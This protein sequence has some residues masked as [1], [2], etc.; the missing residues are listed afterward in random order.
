MSGF[1]QLNLC[2]ASVLRVRAHPSPLQNAGLLINGEYEGICSSR[3][4]GKLAAMY[5]KDY[6]TINVCECLHETN[7]GVVEHWLFF[8]NHL[9]CRWHGYDPIQRYTGVAERESG[10]QAINIGHVQTCVFAPS[11]NICFGS[12]VRV[13]ALQFFKNT[14]KLLGQAKRI[15]ICGFMK[16]VDL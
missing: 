13:D 1:N 16:K 9:A 4:V 10:D 3:A 6:I 12:C 7:L 11:L 15:Y 5:C 14:A 8:T 2:F